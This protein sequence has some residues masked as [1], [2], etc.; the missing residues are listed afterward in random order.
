MNLTK[1]ITMSFSG[2]IKNICLIWSVVSSLDKLWNILCN[3]DCL[4]SDIKWMRLPKLWTIYEN[5]DVWIKLG[6]I[7]TTEDNSVDISTEGGDENVWNVHKRE[8]A[9]G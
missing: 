6:F 1:E 8:F 7:A 2:R 9:N 3:S 4:S 5:G